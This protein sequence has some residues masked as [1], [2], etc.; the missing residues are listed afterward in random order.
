MTT[1]GTKKQTISVT[2]QLEETHDW[3]K[4]R[5]WLKLILRSHGL[6]CLSVE[7][8]K[9]VDVTDSTEDAKE[10]VDASD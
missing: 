10:Q 6:K 7:P 9:R 3:C 8:A 4:L 5:R 1:N 2:I